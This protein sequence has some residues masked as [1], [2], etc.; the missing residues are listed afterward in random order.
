MAT[1]DV[2]K[3]RQ[4]YVPK[5]WGLRSAQ[6]NAR[7]TALAQSAKDHMVAYLKADESPLWDWTIVDDILGDF[8][9]GWQCMV[10][11]KKYQDD[12][13]LS[14]EVR[15]RVRSF[16]DKLVATAGFDPQETYDSW[17]DRYTLGVKERGKWRNKRRRPVG[18]YC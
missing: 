18:Y 11:P 14:P 17:C 16:H 9:R 10:N 15:E 13:V 3:C 7:L 6:A 1:S 4:V 12:G 5:H 8:M 2:L